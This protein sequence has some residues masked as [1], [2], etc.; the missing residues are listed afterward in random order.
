MADVA[1][2]TD[3]AAWVEAW[4]Q[5]R[6]LPRGIDP[7]GRIVASVETDAAGMT[8]R[9]VRIARTDG[10]PALLV[11]QVHSIDRISTVHEPQ[12]HAACNSWNAAHRVPRAWISEHD[13][14]LKVV[15][16]SSV[17]LEALTEEC[18]RRTGDMT[19]DAAVDFWHWV[20]LKTDW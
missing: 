16:E 12:V 20:D 6:R 13:A 8:T 14:T 17:P 1:A 10:K 11:L 2:L 7:T 3:L 9:E 19:I 4:L 15:I 18:V 5:H